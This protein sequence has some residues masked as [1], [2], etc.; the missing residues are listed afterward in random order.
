MV[1]GYKARTC[2]ASV[3]NDSVKKSVSDI[4]LRGTRRGLHVAHGHGVN[5]GMRNMQVLKRSVILWQGVGLV[6]EIML[7]PAGHGPA[8]PR[9]MALDLADYPPL[10]SAPEYPGLRRPFTGP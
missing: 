4:I 2:A 5:K 3:V 1:T 6:K 7:L 10:V 8:P 9:S